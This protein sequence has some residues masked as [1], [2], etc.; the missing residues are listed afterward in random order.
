MLQIVL[1]AGKFAFL[2]I[3]YLFIFWVVRSTTREL[4]ASAVAPAKQTWL[5]EVG[6]TAP[7]GGG[8][9]RGA[10]EAVGTGVWA[11]VVEQSP[12]LPQGGVFVFPPGG[13]VLAGRSHETDIQLSDTFVSSRHALFEVTDEGLVV[14]DLDSTNGTQV[15]GND[16]EAPYLLR[17]GDRVEIGDT[18]FRVELR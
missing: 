14:E 8:G 4:R 2:V 11:L 10:P 1:L 17:P 15:N 7:A 5:P 6:V 13:R 12:V 16:V 3:L 9:V 18:V